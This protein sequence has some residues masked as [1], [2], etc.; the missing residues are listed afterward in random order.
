MRMEE[1]RLPI[2][3]D[4]ARLESSL[5]HLNTSPCN[6]QPLFDPPIQPGLRVWEIRGHADPG[7]VLAS[8]SGRSSTRT[9]NVQD[10]PS[11]VDTHECASAGAGAKHSAGAESSVAPSQRVLGWKSDRVVREREIKV[12]AAARHVFDEADLDCDGNLNRDDIAGLLRMLW[13]RIARP[14]QAGEDMDQM[15]RDETTDVL[16]R[17]DT[18][19]DGTITFGEFLVMVCQ[20]SWRLLLPHEVRANT[21]FL[22]QA[23]LT[24][25]SASPAW[26]T[27]AQQSFGEDAGAMFSSPR[28]GLGLG[29]GIPRPAAR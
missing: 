6:N 19:H 16:Q 10:S 13:Q 27:G 24:Q 7:D 21:P 25:A 1:G 23:L 28:A 26:S 9:V 15:L 22:A 17:F 3:S 12:A 2:W 8:S 18:S 29:L 20:P 14:P 4:V 5:K 11:I